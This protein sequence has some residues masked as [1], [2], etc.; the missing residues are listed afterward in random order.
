MKQ[1]LHCDQF[2]K[3]LGFR[4]PPLNSPQKP[5]T[6]LQTHG[7]TL[8]FIPMLHRNIFCKLT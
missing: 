1:G 6:L 8:N 4:T 5:Q 3:T 2:V 7:I